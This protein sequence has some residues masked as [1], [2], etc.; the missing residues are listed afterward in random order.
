MPAAYLVTGSSGFIG[1]HVCAQAR[2]F[3]PP[4]AR[5]HGLDLAPPAARS[6]YGHIHADIRNT[7]S[8][9][10]L[11]ILNPEAIIHLAARAEVLMPFKELAD[12]SSTNVNGTAN[13]MLQAKPRTF[14][15]ASSSAVYGSVSGEGVPADF[16]FV[17]P[18]G[19]YG[20]SKLFGEMVCEEWCREGFG[21]A[22][23][24]RFGNVIGP[25]CR[26]LIPFLVQHAL[27]H[28]GGAIEAQCRGRGLILRDY[29]PV[30][31]IVQLLWAAAC[32]V[33]EPGTFRVFNA[34]TGRGMTNGQVGNIVMRV[35]GEQGYRLN[36]SWDAPLGPGESSSIVLGV[37]ETSETFGIPP[38]NQDAVVASIEAAV[39]SWLAQSPEHAKRDI[40]ACSGANHRA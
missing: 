27:S 13:V 20:V 32:R 8:L 37:D 10:N 7:E 39:I 2:Q 29:V 22:V 26:G 24:F 19:A 5:L 31:H 23:V 14:V 15:F 4:G 1:T 35:L 11:R 25:H 16:R 21:A 33:W 38:P 30:Q 3:L 28:P 34:G 18:V 9:A 6:A 17:K 36:I 12:L 40:A